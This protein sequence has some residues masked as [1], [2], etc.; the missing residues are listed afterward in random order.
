MTVWVALGKTA[1]GLTGYRLSEGQIDKR[2]TSDNDATLLTE[3]GPA[4]R[5]IRLGEGTPTRLPA[6]V[7]PDASDAKSVT[8]PALEQTS[9]PDIASGWVRLWIAG[10][11]AHCPNWDGVICATHGDVTHWLHVSAGEVVSMQSALT[12]RLVTT[13][14][15]ALAPCATA[16][17]DTISR[18]ERLAAHLRQA[19][20]TGN[21]AAI[22]GHLLGAE[23]S[24][25]RPYWLGQDVLVIAPCPEAHVTALSEQGVPATALDLEEAQSEGLIALVKALET[26]TED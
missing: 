18:P 15:G 3:L 9:P 10:A 17:G 13:L 20:V 22:T 23:L 7:L 2:A 4:D 1:E 6:P 14:G 12:P 21:R 25:M 11:L 8:L 26:V 24:A 16:L 5:M 19:E